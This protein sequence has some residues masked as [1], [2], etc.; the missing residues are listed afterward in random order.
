VGFI[1]PHFY[2]A[3]R[4][5]G[6]QH[7]SFGRWIAENVRGKIAIAL[8]NDLVMMNLL[9]TRAG[10]SG[11]FNLHA[12]RSGL[13]TTYPGSFNNAEE[14]MEWFKKNKV[15]HLAIDRSYRLEFN[16]PIYTGKKIPKYWEEIY[17]IPAP[18]TFW[19]IEI[20]KINWQ[21]YEKLKNGKD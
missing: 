8:N 19:D 21:E 17:S 13:E 16:L 10:G 18:S 11:L 2:W 14:A 20:Y 1:Y 15:T 12:S 4:Y 5:D 6:Y 3:I 9:D 7:L